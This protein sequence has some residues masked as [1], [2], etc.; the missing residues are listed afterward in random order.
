[1]Q[2]PRLTKTNDRGIFIAWTFHMLQVNYSTNSLTR[3]PIRIIWSNHQKNLD[4]KH[5]VSKETSFEVA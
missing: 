1:L 5:L 3:L 2:S 4:H